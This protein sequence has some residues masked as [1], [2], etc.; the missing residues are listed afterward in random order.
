MQL[1]NSPK[2]CGLLVM[3]WG[4]LKWQLSELKEAGFPGS[5]R[6]QTHSDLCLFPS[7]RQGFRCRRRRHA[8]CA[9]SEEDQVFV[10]RAAGGV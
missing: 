4:P 6:T 1:F 3:E 5:L 2:V 8:G 10:P 7:G 9:G